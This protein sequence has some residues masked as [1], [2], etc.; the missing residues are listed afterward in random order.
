MAI[1]QPRIGQPVT[2]EHVDGAGYRTIFEG[3]VQQGEGDPGGAGDS[4]LVSLARN[5]A[6]LE[7]DDEVRVRY[8]DD[9]GLCHFQT[10]ILEVCAGAR[11][12]VRLAP[13]EKV[14]RQQRRRFFRLPVQVPAI[15]ARLDAKGDSVEECRLTTLE[16]GGNGAGMLSDRAFTVGERVRV[17]L[18]LGDK[19][20]AA[21]GIGTVKRSVL[22]LVPTGAEHR[23]AV[24]FVQIDARSQAK[25]LSFLLAR[26]AEANKP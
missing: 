14:E 20:G 2:L 11:V 15:C 19:W 22:A 9:K 6:L 8:C 16:I 10:R 26:K 18:E 7:K 25:I 24:Q 5:D 4:S 12:E 17:K 21:E 23:V 3:I 1:E 13:P